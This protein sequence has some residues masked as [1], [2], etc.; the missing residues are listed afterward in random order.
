[1]EV[2]V[3]RL[4]LAQQ[5]CDAGRGAISVLMPVMR[6]REMRVVMHQ[7][8]VTVRVAMA[9]S[10]RR[11]TGFGVAVLMVLVVAVRVVVFDRLMGVKVLVALGQ[12]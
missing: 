10:A 7:G 2:R 1:M 9:F 11:V 12:M 4:N 6:I 3:E 8:F 5:Q